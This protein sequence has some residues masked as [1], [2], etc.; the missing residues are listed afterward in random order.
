MCTIPRDQV[1][2]D[3]AKITAKFL[4]RKSEEPQI[5][6][7]EGKK[8]AP[9]DFLYAPRLLGGT[10]PKK[11]IGQI[12]LFFFFGSNFDLKTIMGTRKS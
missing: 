3:E 11:K 4:L 10:R 9:L 1:R 2:A 8:I 6:Q 7:K 5:G 12:G